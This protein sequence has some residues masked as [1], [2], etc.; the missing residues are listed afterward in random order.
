V[1]FFA[2]GADVERDG[3]YTLREV[4]TAPAAAQAIDTLHS[5]DGVLEPAGT[6]QSHLRSVEIT[7]DTAANPLG[8][9]EEAYIGVPAAATDSLT[10]WYDYSANTVTEATPTSTVTTEFGDVDLYSAAAAPSPTDAAL[11]Y[12]LPY[13]EQGKTDC[14]VWDDRGT[15]LDAKTDAE[16]IVQWQRCFTTSHEFQGR[17]VLSNA[18][19]RVRLDTDPTT[20]PGLQAERWDGQNDQWADVTLAP[21]DNPDGWALVDADLVTIGPAALEAQ[22]LF[23]A[24]DGTQ[25][26]LN[27]RLSRGDDV[28][29]FTTPPNAPNSTPISLQDVVS[30]I[31]SERLQTAGESLGLRDREGVRR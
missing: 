24:D 9:T 18:R 28:L 30:P 20:Q 25:R 1:P 5:F 12:D 29:L 14:K 6:R 13:A 21:N 31:A 7:R 22:L 10:R 4:D 3:Y 17:P 27:A 2:V 16:G 11:V 23:R 26:P 19:L 8:T 15:G